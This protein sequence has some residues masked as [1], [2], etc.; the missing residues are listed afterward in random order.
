MPSAALPAFPSRYRNATGTCPCRHHRKS[1]KHCPLHIPGP[2][3]A[4]LPAPWPSPSQKPFLTKD[5]EVRSTPALSR[6]SRHEDIENKATRQSPSDISQPPMA[7]PRCPCPADKDGDPS[8]R[9]EQSFFGV[10]GGTGEEGAVFT[11]KR[12]FLPRQK[13]HPSLPKLPAAH[14]PA[15]RPQWRAARRPCPPQPCGRR[16]GRQP[17]APPG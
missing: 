3:A 9:P 15:R 14:A 1:I 17:G 5:K 8:Y 7:I 13:L 10:G 2:L 11:K 4:A 16:C 6:T 12:P